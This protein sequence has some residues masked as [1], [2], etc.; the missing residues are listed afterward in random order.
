[1]NVANE[2]CLSRDVLDT[3]HDRR[4]QGWL[5]EG[6]IVLSDGPD[7]QQGLSWREEVRK[8][9]IGEV[10]QSC[11]SGGKRRVGYSYIC[12]VWRTNGETKEEE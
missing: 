5:R 6:K 10:D 4:W 2:C 11:H 8:G 12:W 1:M 9:A 7:R 3:R